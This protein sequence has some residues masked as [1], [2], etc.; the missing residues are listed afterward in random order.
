MAAELV[1]FQALVYGRVQGVFF[2]AYVVRRARELG[3]SG[4]VRNLADGSVEVR[5]E[6]E[7]GNLEKLAGLLKTGPPGARVIRIDTKWSEY[8]S[9]YSDFNIL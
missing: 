4:Y 1:S 6:G 9:R 3:L 2:R 7:R 5:G 8:I